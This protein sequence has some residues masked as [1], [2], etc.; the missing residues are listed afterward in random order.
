MT[1]REWIGAMK[2]NVPSKYE[3]TFSG[4]KVK[5]S[6]MSCEDLVV[7][8][9]SATY[10]APRS[11]EFAF[12]G[13][14]ADCE[15]DYDWKYES[16]LGNIKGDGKVKASIH[17][18]SATFRVDINADD[19]GAPTELVTRKCDMSLSVDDV[20]L[21]GDPVGDAARTP[22]VVATTNPFFVKHSVT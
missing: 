16:W 11:L 20:S 18:T 9:L 8:S 15:G 10:D 17:R 4:V 19:W 22:G 2:I 3:D 6:D 1:L 21:R 12:G 7:G 5:V 13:I 14:E